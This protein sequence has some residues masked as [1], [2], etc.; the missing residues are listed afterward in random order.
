MKP[1]RVRAQP[2][3]VLQRR[4]L[5]QVIGGAAGPVVHNDHV[6]NPSNTPLKD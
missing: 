5:S 6:E 3:R 2:V 4:E 1:V